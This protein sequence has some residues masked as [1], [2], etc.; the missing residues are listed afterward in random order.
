MITSSLIDAEVR[1]RMITQPD[2]FSAFFKLCFRLWEWSKC[3]ATRIVFAAIAAVTIAC[4]P[5]TSFLSHFAQNDD[6]TS[7]FDFYTVKTV[8]SKTGNS[9]YLPWCPIATSITIQGR[10]LENIPKS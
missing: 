7:K 4:V 5:G 3:Y 1:M 8:E 6:K 9:Q 2:P 10:D